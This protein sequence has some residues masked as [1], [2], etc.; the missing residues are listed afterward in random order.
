MFLVPTPA[1]AASP[2]AAR[3]HELPLRVRPE[4]CLPADSLLPGHIPA[5]DA[6]FPAVGNRVMFTPISAMIVCTVRWLTLGDGVEPISERL[7][8]SILALT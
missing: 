2:S 1:A 4:W 5:Q 6:K 3:N 7:E 8:R